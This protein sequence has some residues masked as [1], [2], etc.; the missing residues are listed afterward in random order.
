MTVATLPVSFPA[1]KGAMSSGIVFA[2]FLATALSASC[3]API[4][5]MCILITFVVALLAV[6]RAASVS[7]FAPLNMSIPFAT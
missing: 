4:V 5:A 2:L 6:L 3:A 7:I 1:S